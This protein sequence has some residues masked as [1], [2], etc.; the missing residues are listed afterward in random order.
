MDNRQVVSFLQDFRGSTQSDFCQ[1]PMGTAI[2][3]ADT[4][5]AHL[6]CEEARSLWKSLVEKEDVSVDDISCIVLDV[7]RSLGMSFFTGLTPKD[8]RISIATVE[9]LYTVYPDFDRINTC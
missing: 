9:Q 5:L 4:T 3:E 6:L 8:S 1:L 7:S 2:T